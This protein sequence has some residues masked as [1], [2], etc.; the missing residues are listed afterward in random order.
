MKYYRLKNPNW[1]GQSPTGQWRI[2]VTAEHEGEEKFVRLASD[3]GRFYIKTH[4]VQGCIAVPSRFQLDSKE[5]HKLRRYIECLNVQAMEEVTEAQIKAE[6]T[7]DMNSG[8]DWLH[9]D[10]KESLRPGTNTGNNT[11]PSNTTVI[12]NSP[13]N[14]PN[15]NLFGAR[16]DVG[17]LT[18]RTPTLSTPIGHPKFIGFASVGDDKATDE[19]LIEIKTQH[20]SWRK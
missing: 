20:L 11:S 3:A 9:E 7:I 12:T 19:P 10:R 1:D 8:F 16:K 13:F 14:D 4:P 6:E 5:F 18:S 2:A 15:H 17:T